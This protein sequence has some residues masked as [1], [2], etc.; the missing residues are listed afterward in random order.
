M[1]GAHQDAVITRGL[2]REQ[3]VRAY[4]G[5][6]NTFTYGLLYGRQLAAADEAER[7][8]PAAAEAARRRK[9][10]RW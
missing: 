8:V 3:A 4:L 7:K 10:R 6:E 1:L 9:L 2:L 5:R